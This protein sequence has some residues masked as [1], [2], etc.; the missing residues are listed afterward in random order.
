MNDGVF[1]VVITDKCNAK[2]PYCISEQTPDVC[3]NYEDY[4]Y[5]NLSKA[6]QYATRA[7]I[8]TCKLTGKKGDPLCKFTLL[9]YIFKY[10]Q[11]AFPIIEIQTNGIGLNK[12]RCKDLRDHGATV[13]SL[14]CIH[15]DSSENS[16]VY[17]A[18][19][20]DLKET[21]SM[22]HAYGLSVRLSCTLIKGWIDDAFKIDS[23]LEF[24][25]DSKVE[26]FS[27]IPVGYFG[28]NLYAQWAKEHQVNEDVVWNNIKVS[29]SV[30]WKN[31]LRWSYI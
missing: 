29:G 28:T 31:F 11:Q 8:Q 12:A 18:S 6:I 25:E 3:I 10:I 22:L 2:C 27:F 20:P 5:H 15:W 26:Q 4:N 9:K 23:F 21:I 1:N 16:A 19:Y 13:V 30:L 17:K 14:S 7:Q 24:F